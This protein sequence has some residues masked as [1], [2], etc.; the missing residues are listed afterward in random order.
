MIIKKLKMK[1]RLQKVSR[2]FN[3]K[4]Q[5]IMFINKILNK[6]IFKKRKKINKENRNIKID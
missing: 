4:N 2:I 6:I 1:Y 5:W 3:K